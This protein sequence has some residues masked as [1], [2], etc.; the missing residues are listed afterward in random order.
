MLDSAF[1][2]LSLVA[3][4]CAIDPFSGG[5][6]LAFYVYP[7]PSWAH[8]TVGS[9]YNFDM[10]FAGVGAADISAGGAFTFNAGNLPSDTWWDRGSA[11]I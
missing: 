10:L 5:G 9:V 7:S 4:A 3:G 6:A 11:M 8:W 2:F 1:L